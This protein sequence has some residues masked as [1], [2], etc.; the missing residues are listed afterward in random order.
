MTSITLV[1]PATNSWEIDNG[2]GYEPYLMRFVH[3][4]SACLGRACV[5]HAPTEHVM[6]HLPLHWRGDR[7]IFERICPHGVGHPDPDQGPYWAET[8]Q[9][10]LWVHGCDGCC[11]DPEPDP[12]EALQEFFSE[13]TY[14]IIV[15]GVDPGIE[16]VKDYD[17]STDDYVAFKAKDAA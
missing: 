5:I 7:A 13:P 2:E 12:M 8:D 17:A 9:G 1:D 10:Y 16:F 4:A 15:N 3:P 14:R 6:S 11:Y